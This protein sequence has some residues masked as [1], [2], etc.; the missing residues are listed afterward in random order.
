MREQVLSVQKVV[1]C[2]VKVEETTIPWL[3]AAD[4]PEQQVTRISGPVLYMVKTYVGMFFMPCMNASS[5]PV[6]LLTRYVQQLLPIY[7]SDSCS[8]GF[9]LLLLGSWQWEPGSGVNRAQEQFS[10]SDTAAGLWVVWVKLRN[11]V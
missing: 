2:A 5:V 7:A 3:M 6:F 1:W 11:L 4:S 8:L 10:R 9:L